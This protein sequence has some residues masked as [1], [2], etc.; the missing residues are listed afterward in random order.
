M[1][2]S[3][4]ELIEVVKSTELAPLEAE[5]LLKS[6]TAFFEEAKGWEQKAKTIV[7]TQETQVTEMAQAKE[8]RI[9]LKRIR[10]DAEN[11][12]KELK[13]KSLREGKAIDGIA[14]VIKALVVPIE[15]YLEKQE[16]FLEIRQE[17]RV[18][19]MEQ[20]RIELLGKYLENPSFYNLKEMSEEGFHQLL[21]TS[22]VAFETKLAAEKKAEDDRIKK[23][24]ADKKEQERMKIENEKLQK[25]A[26]AREKQMKIEREEAQVAREKIL[27]EKQ[28][29]IEAREKVERELKEKKDAEERLKGEEAGRIQAEKELKERLG[30][31]TRYKDFLAKNKYSSDTK[32]LFH[33]ERTGE[34]VKL[35]KLV[36]T[37]NIN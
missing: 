6:F 23:E 14:N 21:D 1:K 13:E 10:V 32:H 25:D 34:Q 19:K 16:K 26:E 2:N 7:V 35:Y 27:R 5:V 24:A 11:K 18:K 37:F 17:E 3:N 33:V 15:E 29:E 9:A 20:D 30:K 22:K 12:R 4:T 36:G 28:G 8:A 31:E